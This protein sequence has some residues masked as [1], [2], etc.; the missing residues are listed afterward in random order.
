MDHNDVTPLAAKADELL[1]GKA[2]EPMDEKAVEPDDGPPEPM[3]QTDPLAVEIKLSAKDLW[4]FSMYFSYKGLKGIFNLVFTLAAIY[5]LAA[6]WN[7]VAA[8]Y[9]VLL[10]LC[11]LMFTVWHPSLLYLKA[12]KQSKSPAIKNPTT[13]SFSREGIVVTQVDKRLELTWEE[14]AL[15]EQA[16]ALMIL[17]MDRVHAYLLPDSL[18]GEGKEALCALIREMLPG[19]RRK[20]V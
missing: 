8:W 6:D 9:R 14:V 2:G 4:K 10:I 16:G 18:T 3:V 17:Y 5:L 12:A 15:V 1:Q 19:E 7:T 13:L 11:A 20:R